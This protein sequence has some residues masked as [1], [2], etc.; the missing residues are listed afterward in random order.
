MGGVGLEAKGAP[1]V[2]PEEDGS[3]DGAEEDKPGVSHSDLLYEE[4]LD[5]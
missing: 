4:L 3:E 5:F 1:G 2:M